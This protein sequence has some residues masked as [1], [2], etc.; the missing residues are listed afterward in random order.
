MKI[1]LNKKQLKTLSAS[2]EINNLATQ[3]IAAG[4]ANVNPASWTSVMIFCDARTG[5]CPV[6]PK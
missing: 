4:H 6:D 2:K 1:Q 5:L 3:K